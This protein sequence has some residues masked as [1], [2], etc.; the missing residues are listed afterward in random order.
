MQPGDLVK[1][2]AV[3]GG[4]ART[5]TVFHDSPPQSTRIPEGTGVVFLG[6]FG[7]GN[8]CILVEGRVGWVWAEELEAL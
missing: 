7:T 3:Y 4:D 2:V 6:Y 1:L 5:V 8:P